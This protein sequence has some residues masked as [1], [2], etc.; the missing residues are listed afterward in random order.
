M[1]SLDIAFDM[2]GGNVYM[3]GSVSDIKEITLKIWQL[4]DMKKFFK[5]WKKK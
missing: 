1:F 5:L 2:G 3:T 4:F